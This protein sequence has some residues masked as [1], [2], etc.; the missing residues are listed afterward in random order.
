M[1]L[2][3]MLQV[4]GLCNFL[5]SC[6]VLMHFTVIDMTFLLLEILLIGA[7]KE[8]IVHKTLCKKWSVEIAVFS[9]SILIMVE[10]G[11]LDNCCCLG[12]NTTCI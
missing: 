12:I 9:H 3:G 2:A 8:L 11:L 10:E 5:Y 4:I 1:L 6:C 7:C